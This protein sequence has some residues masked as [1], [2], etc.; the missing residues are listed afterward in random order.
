[1]ECDPSS[2]LCVLVDGSVVPDS[3]SAS[4]DDGDATI[5]GEPAE[6]PLDTGSD[7]WAGNDSTT[8]TG[9]NEAGPCMGLTCKC[10]GNSSCDSHICADQLT[11]GPGVY[12]AAG[13]NSFCTKPCCTSADCD[14]PTVCYA[15]SSNA[16]SGNYCVMPAWLGRATEL[17]SGQ[18]GESCTDDTNCRSGLCAMG[19]CAD[20]CCSTRQSSSECA[21]GT[22]CSFG[23]FPGTP[24]FDQNYTPYCAQAGTGTNGTNCNFASDCASNVCTSPG[25]CQ[26]AC[27]SAADC[28]GRGYSCG[29]ARNQ[30]NAVFPACFSSALAGS[31]GQPCQRNSDCQSG[32]C[33]MGAKCTD[34]CF[35]DKDCTVSGWYCRPEQITLRSGGVA[36]VLCCGP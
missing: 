12:M 10:S 18:G 1:M 3:D 22:T 11:I 28:S 24:S 31:E 27:R 14:P 32:L 34:V 19:T 16:S 35:S 13:S 20:T 2:H 6:A 29:Y 23:T 8:D 26:D 17:G 25:V 36:S 5:D 4:A 9:A 15:T 21:S 30:S 7:T 33:D